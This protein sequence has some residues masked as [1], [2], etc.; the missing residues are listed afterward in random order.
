MKSQKQIS[1]CCGAMSAKEEK[2]A[3]TELEIH[4]KYIEK[5]RSNNGTTQEMIQNDLKKEQYYQ[6]ATDEEIEEG[7]AWIYGDLKTVQNEYLKWFELL[8]SFGIGAIAYYGPI[9]LLMFQKIMR[10]MEMENEVM[11]FQTI[12]LML[13]K[14]ERVNVE[15]ILDWLERYSN[16]FR[17][18]IT[19]CVNNYESGAW[20]ALEELL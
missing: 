15:M 10:Q 7:A 1:I 2:K 13:M 8:I 5:Y 6:T 9:W 17:E 14:I 18:P 19:K 3:A 16:I 11:Q 12:I 20:E 4:N